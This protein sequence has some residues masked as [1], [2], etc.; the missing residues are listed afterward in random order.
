[1]NVDKIE[2]GNRIRAIREKLN[3]SMNDFSILIDSKKS[4]VNSWERGL[5]IPK[6]NMLKKIALLGKVS[7]DEIL[8]GSPKEYIK[9]LVGLHFPNVELTS[10]QYRELTEAIISNDFSYENDLYTVLQITKYI[11]TLNSKVEPIFYLKTS[12]HSTYISMSRYEKQIDYFLSVDVKRNIVHIMPFTFQPFDL[13][14]FIKLITTDP[15]IVEAFNEHLPDINVNMKAPLHL[16][17]YDMTKNSRMNERF[18][19]FNTT[20]KKYDCL[21]EAEELEE[22]FGEELPLSFLFQKEI[23]KEIWFQQA[24]FSRL[25]S[26]TLDT[27]KFIEENKL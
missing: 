26:M 7:I 2:V 4:T 5:A 22:H 1:M 20:T 16:I 11:E 25:T 15:A 18:F 27:K 8:Y 6:E 23:L 21:K 3:Y 17:A 9:K 14:L 12:L 13:N 10:K 24:G 19:F